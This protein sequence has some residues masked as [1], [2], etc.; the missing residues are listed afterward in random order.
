METVAIP[1]AII[2]HFIFMAEK[3]QPVF[4][5]LLDYFRQC[6]WETVVERTVLVVLGQSTS[7]SAD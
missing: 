6:W 7:L 2:L 4:W 3:A 5:F 1:A